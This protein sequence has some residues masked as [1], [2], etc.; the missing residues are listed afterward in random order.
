[1]SISTW[2]DFGHAQVPLDRMDDLISFPITRLAI[3]ISTPFYTSFVGFDTR[4]R[5]CSAFTVNSA[6]HCLGLKRCQIARA[7]KSCQRFFVDLEI[8]AL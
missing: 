7:N 1:M 3:F 2:A 4:L 6:K 8:I 5:L